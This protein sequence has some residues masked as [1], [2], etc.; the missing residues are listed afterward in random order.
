MSQPLDVPLLFRAMEDRMEERMNVIMREL[1][2]TNDRYDEFKTG[3]SR[4]LDKGYRLMVRN[5][6]FETGSTGSATF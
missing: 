6:G 2:R 4:S 3:L 1:A 5:W